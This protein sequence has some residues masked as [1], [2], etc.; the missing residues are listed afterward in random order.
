VALDPAA[1]AGSDNEYAMSLGRLGVMIS[2]HTHHLTWVSDA[3]GPQVFA[4]RTNAAV[5]GAAVRRTLCSRST[6]AE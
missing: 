6:E 4:G 5:R 3:S 2:R 1:S